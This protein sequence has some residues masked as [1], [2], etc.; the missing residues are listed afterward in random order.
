MFTISKN[1]EVEGLKETI[2]QVNK[3]DKLA[4]KALRD[5]IKSAITPTAK[6][7]ASKVPTRS[8]LSGFNRGRLRWTGAKARVAFTPGTIRRGK[9]VHPLVS[10]VMS[11]KG[12]GAAFELTEVAGSDKLAQRSQPRT[13]VGERYGKPYSRR[14]PKSMSRNFEARLNERA[15]WRYQAGRFGFGYFLREKKDIQ[16]IASKILEGHRKKLTKLAEKAR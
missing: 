3:V 7:I 2:R 16:K 15:P 14:N 11:S 13:R 1:V 6:S 8:P 10:V 4:V 5:E 9:D 12:S